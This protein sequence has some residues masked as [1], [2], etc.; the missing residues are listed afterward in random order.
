M[1]SFNLPKQVAQ[2]LMHRLGQKIVSEYDLEIPQSQT[3]DYQYPWIDK[4]LKNYLC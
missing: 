4:I 2:K 3:A 1:T